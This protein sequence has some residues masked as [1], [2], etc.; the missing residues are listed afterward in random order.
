[1]QAAPEFSFVT[2]P[3]RS[4]VP[5]RPLGPRVSLQ[6]INSSV[7][8][9]RNNAPVYDESRLAARRMSSYGDLKSSGCNLTRISERSSDVSK[10]SA[11]VKNLNLRE[12]KPKPGRSIDSL[13]SAPERIES[14]K[15][16]PTSESV[17]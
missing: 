9:R 10:E 7:V 14:L 16:P 2:K 17:A 11:A 5:T 8:L 4:V 15:K 3:P 13:P 6:D 12:V 1:M